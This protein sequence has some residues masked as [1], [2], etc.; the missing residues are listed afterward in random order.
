MKYGK[1]EAN[2]NMDFNNG[3]FKQGKV[4]KYRY[5]VEKQEIFI[6]TEEGIE[7]EFVYSEFDMLF[8][9]LKN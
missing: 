7:Q 2:Y 4:Y 6:T 5:D 3:H 9:L 1:V 8:T